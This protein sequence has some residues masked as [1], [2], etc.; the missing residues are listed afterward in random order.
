MK[1]LS[2]SAYVQKINE[3]ILLEVA[4]PTSSMNGR[5]L[6]KDP[7]MEV[8]MYLGY[9]H[10]YDPVA[11]KDAEH[12]MKRQL[13]KDHPDWTTEQIEM[14]I[15]QANIQAK[16][17]SHGQWTGKEAGLERAT[18]WQFVGVF[19][20]P[21]D[22][23]II[24]EK[25]QQNHGDIEATT[26]QCL[27][28]NEPKLD[29]VGGITYN[30]KF[31]YDGKIKSVKMTGS[32]GNSKIAKGIALTNFIHEMDQQGVGVLTPADQE[33]KE[34]LVKLDAGG[35]LKKMHS[36]GV[37]TRP[38]TG[39]MKPPAD[40]MPLI[41]KFLKDDSDMRGG[42][43]I[44]G[45]DTEPESP[46]KTEPSNRLLMTLPGVGTVSKHIMANEPFW[47]KKISAAVNKMIGENQTLLKLAKNP[48]TP[49][50]LV[51]TGVNNAIKNYVPDMKPLSYDSIK[52]LLQF[53]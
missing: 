7:A 26:E 5:D 1:N 51:T 21:E 15:A 48:L 19:P 20:K 41:Y 39:L 49:K 46:E 23:N 2:F 36:Q 34:M 3:S 44:V 18:K 4:E 38:S 29:Y 53:V 12:N 35:L 13:K 33:L 9:R 6:F 11:K 32:F 28:E 43:E 14:Q 47:R 22:L 45:L 50:F 31:D 52:W 17:W 40:L 10:A 25:L 30:P 8:A 42:G 27:I 16:P 37:V 24:R